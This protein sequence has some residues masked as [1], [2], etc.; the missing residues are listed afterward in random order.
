MP[1]W[2]IH[3]GNFESY[4]FSVGCS[5]QHKETKSADYGTMVHF[6]RDWWFSTIIPAGSTLHLKRSA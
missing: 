5:T 1:K 3:S 4:L 6:E 2:N